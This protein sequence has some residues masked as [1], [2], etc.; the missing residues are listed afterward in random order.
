M[1]PQWPAALEC[2]EERD[3]F[4]IQEQDNVIRSPTETGPGKTRPRE[5]RAATNVQFALL[6]DNVRRDILMTFYRDDTH[7]GTL[8]FDSPYIDQ[9]V[10]GGRALA[11]RLTAPPKIMAMGLIFR[12]PIA[13][14]G[15]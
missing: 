5:T 10:G 13:V 14:E 6:L 12:V 3:S 1:R 8:S 11:Y 2:R 9:I 7:Y 4:V 15:W